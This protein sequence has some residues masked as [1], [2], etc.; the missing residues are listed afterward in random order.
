MR[1]T[2]IER[3]SW[4]GSRRT[5]PRAC[6][7]A[8]WQTGRGFGNNGVTLINQR[9]VSLSGLSSLSGMSGLLVEPN[10]PDE[11]NQPDKKIN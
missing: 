1:F 7:P 5:E 8:N 2:C 6:G 4:R 9:L 10:E 11:P 3:V